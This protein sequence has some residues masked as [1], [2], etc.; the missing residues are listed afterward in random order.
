MG[1]KPALIASDVS[2]R[3]RIKRVPADNAFRREAKRLAD[4][5]Q[6][7]E[8]LEYL[9]LSGDAQQEHVDA[10]KRWIDANIDPEDLV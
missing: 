4:E 3:D 10:H 5:G 6:L 2:V 7:L 9:V 1:A 8:A